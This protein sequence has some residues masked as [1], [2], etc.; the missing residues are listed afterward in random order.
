MSPMLNAVNINSTVV[1][2][3]CALT[4]VVHC[5]RS[6]TGYA[7]E[8][9]SMMNSTRREMAPTSLPDRKNSFGSSFGSVIMM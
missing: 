2:R 7:D 6:S 5:A 3:T 1:S 8:S 9:V 4:H